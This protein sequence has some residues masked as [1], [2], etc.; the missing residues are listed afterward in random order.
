MNKKTF[1][2]LL[3]ALISLVGIKFL[4]GH[5]TA[6]T[7]SFS[8]WENKDLGVYCRI[9]PYD[10]FMPEGFVGKCGIRIN[11]SGKLKILPSI[12]RLSPSAEKLKG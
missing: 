11:Y 7:P 1:V 10:C 12:S 2:F 3:M 5:G 8:W 9:C 6:K 4:Q